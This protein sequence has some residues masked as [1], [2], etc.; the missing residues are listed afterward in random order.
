MKLVEL[1]SGCGGFSRGAHDAGF[2][3]AAAY[4]ID[5]ILTSA[6]QANF[7]D[8]PLHLRDVAELTGAQIRKDVGGEVLVCSEVR[9][10]K[11]S[12]K[13]VSATRAIRAAI[14]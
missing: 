14:C 4:D 1:F 6:Y 7:P 8:T 13:S 12:A 11:A 5:P 9:H 3:V 10:A 2:N